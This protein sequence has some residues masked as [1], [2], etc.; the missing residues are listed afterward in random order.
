M[1]SIPSS[2]PSPCRGIIEGMHLRWSSQKNAIGPIRETLAVFR[3]GIS[4]FVGLIMW[5]LA[6]AALIGVSVLIGVVTLLLV[7]VWLPCFLWSK[8]SPKDKSQR[9][10]PGSLLV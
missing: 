10:G 7:L 2:T 9:S 4:L 8:A 5:S 3:E 1:G 6:M